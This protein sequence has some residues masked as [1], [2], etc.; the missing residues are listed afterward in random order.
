MVKFNGGRNLTVAEERFNRRLIPARNLIERCIGVLKLRFRCI[1]GERELRY[2][3]TKVS[4][5]IYACATLHNYLIF[6]RFDILRDINA[7]HLENLIAQ[8]EIEENIPIIVNENQ[9]RVRERAVVI[10]NQ[11]AQHFA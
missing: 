6:N 10:R 7:I 3:P 2:H 5:I 4:K 11:L 8:A 1:L 9:R